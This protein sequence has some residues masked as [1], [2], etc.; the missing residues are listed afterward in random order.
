MEPLTCLS[1]ICVQHKGS[2]DM[3]L[4]HQLLW[5]IYIPLFHGHIWPKQ[6]RDPITNKLLSRPLIVKTESGSGRLLKEANSLDFCEQLATIGVHILGRRFAMLVSLI[7]IL[8]TWWLLGLAIPL[9]YGH[10]IVTFPGENNKDLN[11]G[12]F[13]TNHGEYGKLSKG[14]VWIGWWGGHHL[15][16]PFGLKHCTRSTSERQEYWQGW[17]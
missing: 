9:S 8:Q 14:T 2:M 3:G 17:G 6:N 10:L 13:L 5:S 11:L 4:W 16:L 7:S 1:Y 15:R 12:W